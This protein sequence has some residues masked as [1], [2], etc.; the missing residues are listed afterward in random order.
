MSA[1]V[2]TRAAIETVVLFTHRHP[3]QTEEAV[4]AT[5]DAVA[6]RGGTVVTSPEERA[7]HGESAVGCEEVAQLPGHP[8]L[9]VVLGGDGTILH[10]LRTYAGTL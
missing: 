1:D 10:A 3:E 4:R 8:D 9:C 7:K 2:K 5:V 6:R